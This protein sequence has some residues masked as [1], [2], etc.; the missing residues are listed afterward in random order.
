ML[1]SSAAQKFLS[2][3]LRDSLYVLEDILVRKPHHPKSMVL[4]LRGACCVV[5]LLFCVLRPI[6]LDYQFMFAAA[7]VCKVLIYRHLTPELCAFD[8]PIA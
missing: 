2:N 5:R 8:L 7:E 3:D 1:H 6:H 4:Q